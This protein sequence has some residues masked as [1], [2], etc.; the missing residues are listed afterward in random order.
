MGVRTG[1]AGGLRFLH[2]RRR[3]FAPFH[4]GGRPP[5]AAASL[6]G[7]LW[8]QPWWIALGGVL[9]KT[10]APQAVPGAR[11][12]TGCSPP[13]GAIQYRQDPTDKSVLGNTLFDVFVEV[14]DWGNG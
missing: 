2:Q 5:S 6:G 14:F 4:K 7:L 11:A 13:S 8:S 12:T 1:Q 3:R 9:L 10:A